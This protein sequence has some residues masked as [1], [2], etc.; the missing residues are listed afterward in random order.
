MR[1]TLRCRDDGSFT[2]IQ[3]TDTHFENSEPENQRT[4]ALMEQVLETEP[5]DMVIFTGDVPGPT[6]HHPREA[7]AIA[8]APLVRRNLP[9]AAV[10]GNHDDEGGHA[11]RSELLAI[12]QA[13]P[14]CLTRSG[15]AS[16]SGVGNFLLHVLRTDGLDKA[17]SFCCLDANSYAE[18]PV[19]SHG[20]VRDNQI[21]WFRRAIEQSHPGQA[22][23]P[24][25]PV[26]DFLHIP[27]PEFDE[28]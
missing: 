15:P 12:Q 9:W 16:L 27:P 20:W 7:W 8:T 10:F 21:R 28:V 23:D 25:P 5:A 17:A 26:L 14:G 13:I 24:T 4:A 6:C 22:T 19:G 11:T 1:K 2:L 3:F 18:S